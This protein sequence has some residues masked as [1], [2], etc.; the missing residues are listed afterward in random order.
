M[1]ITPHSLRHSCATHFVLKTHNLRFV[2]IL[3]GH[4]SIATTQIYTHLDNGF[5]REMFHQHHGRQAG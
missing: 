5:V 2:Q 4:K 1:H 3:L